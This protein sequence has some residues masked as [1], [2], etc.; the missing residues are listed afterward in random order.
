MV[1]V[2]PREVLAAARDK[3]ETFVA[4][5]RLGLPHARSALPDRMDSF[6][7]E[8]AF[9][10]VVKPREGHGSIGFHIVNDRQGARAAML[11][12]EKLGWHPLLQEFLGSE[13]QE[14]STGV[15][16]DASGRGVVSSITMRR[17]LKGGQTYKAIVDDFRDVRQMAEEIAMKLGCRGPLNVQ[18]RMVEGQLKVFE[19]NPRISASCP[20]RAKAGVNE[21]DLL[22]RNSVMGEEMRVDTYR[23]VACLRYWNEVYVPLETVELVAEE[24][25]IEDISSAVSQEF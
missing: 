4:L 1:V 11:T 22:Y 10:M 9:P 13:D 14:F 19:L 15:V 17:T 7:R 23:K 18:A 21:P 16:V 24:G 6:V 12:I 2:N 5:R 8:N 25:E 3:W 20:I